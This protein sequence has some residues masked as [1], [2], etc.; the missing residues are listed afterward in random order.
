MRR[1]A[2]VFVTI[3]RVMA[4]FAMLVTVFLAARSQAVM[5]PEVQRANRLAG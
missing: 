2:V 5:M 3:R 4:V 1:V